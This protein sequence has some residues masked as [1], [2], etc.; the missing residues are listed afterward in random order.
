MGKEN[1]VVL[2]DSSLQAKLGVRDEI[3]LKKMDARVKEAIA[4]YE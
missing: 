4:Q 1:A 2:T 3:V